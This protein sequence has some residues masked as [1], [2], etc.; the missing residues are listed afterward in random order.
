MPG[1]GTVD[2]SPGT[3]PSTTIGGGRGRPQGLEQR[4]RLDRRVE[5]RVDD[6]GGD[7]AVGS[8][9][10]ERVAVDRPDGQEVLGGERA[11]DV[12]GP[13]AARQAY[14]HYVDRR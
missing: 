6:H 1:A 13:V 12:D 3:R 7:V 11:P 14:Q 2:A 8:E 9:A 5:G 10:R 4:G